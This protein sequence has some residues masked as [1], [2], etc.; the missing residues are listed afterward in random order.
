MTMTAKELVEIVDELPEEKA[1][2]VVSFA[3]FLRQQAG[4]LAWERV[5]NDAR[6]S[7]KPDGLAG[8]ALR[9][10]RTDPRNGAKL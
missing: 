2:E 6:S 4:D 1:R 8:D 10:R 7:Q 3:R 5:I 9:E